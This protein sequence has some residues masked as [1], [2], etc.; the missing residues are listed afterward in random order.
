[1][2]KSDEFGCVTLSTNKYN[3]RSYDKTF[4]PIGSS[5]TTLNISVSVV[6]EEVVSIGK[7]D[8]SL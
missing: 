4:P 2:D 5:A 8:F 3:F 7:F 1:M 6:I